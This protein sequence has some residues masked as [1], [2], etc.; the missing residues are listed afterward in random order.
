MD[1]QRGTVPPRSERSELLDRSEDV[2]LEPTA[3]ATLE[4]FERKLLGPQL[5][6]QIYGTNHGAYLGTLTDAGKHLLILHER[7]ELLISPVILARRVPTVAQSARL[8]AEFDAQSASPGWG[9][10]GLPTAMALGYFAAIAPR[11]ALDLVAQIR[12]SRKVLPDEGNVYL[13]TV[14]LRLRMSVR[15]VS[16]DA[17]KLLPLAERVREVSPKNAWSFLFEGLPTAYSLGGGS[18]MLEALEKVPSFIDAEPDPFARFRLWNVLALA[19]T[20]TGAHGHAVELLERAGAS[21]QNATVDP[22]LHNRYVSLLDSN[23]ALVLLAAG[24]ADEG[25]EAAIRAVRTAPKSPL[26]LPALW[27]HSERGVRLAA[28]LNRIREWHDILTEEV[29]LMP[30]TFVEDVYYAARRYLSLVVPLAEALIRKGHSDTG[31]SLIRHACSLLDQ[32]VP[33][34]DNFRHRLHEAGSAPPIASTIGGSAC[35]MI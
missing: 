4:H 30:A 28:D 19:A 11:R 21:V 23:M 17:R 35:P 14:D 27:L 5:E 6:A 3:S 32:F 1:H 20:R 22:D 31:S 8:A 34:W 24:R 10:S 33:R 9:E 7:E 12:E 13:D 15:P 18:F 25:F 16:A 2:E 29:D 26:Q